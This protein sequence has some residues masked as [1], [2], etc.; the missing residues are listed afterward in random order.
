MAIDKEQYP[1]NSYND[2]DGRI[3]ASL[4]KE[5][6]EKLLNICEQISKHQRNLT[7]LVLVFVFAI[8]AYMYFYYFIDNAIVTRSSIIISIVF[9]TFIIYIYLG[10]QKLFFL[11]RNATIVSI[12][13]EKVIRAASQAQEHTTMG[14]SFFS[15][16]EV[17][18]RLSDAELALQQYTNLVKK[19]KLFGYF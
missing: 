8:V 18:L 6:A 3:I 14:R 2:G 1:R 10:I 19:R 7:V 13:L 11:E 16:L 4:L 17:D 9:C 15:D 5:Y 12:R